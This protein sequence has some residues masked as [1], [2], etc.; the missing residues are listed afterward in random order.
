MQQRRNDS[1]CLLLA[2]AGFDALSCLSTSFG[3]SLMKDKGL[4]R[5]EAARNDVAVSARCPAS[6]STDFFCLLPTCIPE[7]SQ[8]TS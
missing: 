3:T 2:R 8:I 5:D 1:L 4:L 6:T 7:S